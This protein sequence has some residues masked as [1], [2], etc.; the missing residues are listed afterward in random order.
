MPLFRYTYGDG[1]TQEGDALV[2]PDLIFELVFIRDNARFTADRIRPHQA[3]PI[4]EAMMRH[5]HAT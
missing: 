5:C 1:T 3:H 2:N 4:H